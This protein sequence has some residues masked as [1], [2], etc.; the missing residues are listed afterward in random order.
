[1]FFFTVAAAAAAA[2]FFT[3]VLTAQLALDDKRALCLHDFCLM[4]LRI[5]F[6]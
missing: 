5:A 1:M 4:F 2:K 3:A 6:G